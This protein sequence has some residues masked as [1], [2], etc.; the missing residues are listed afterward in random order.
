MTLSKRRLATAFVERGYL[1]GRAPLEDFNGSPLWRFAT[2]NGTSLF[3][4]ECCRFATAFA[5][6][7]G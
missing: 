7:T 5:W 1:R 6:G 3:V 4:P 2:N